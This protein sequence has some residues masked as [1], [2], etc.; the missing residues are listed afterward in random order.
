MHHQHKNY[1]DKLTLQSTDMKPA[2]VLLQPFCAFM[3]AAVVVQCDFFSFAIGAKYALAS[4]ACIRAKV[5]FL[6]TVSIMKVLTSM[7]GVLC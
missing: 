7:V 6:E 5:S 4:D 1:A 3:P 2:Y